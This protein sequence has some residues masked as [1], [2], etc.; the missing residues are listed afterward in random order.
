MNPANTT[1]P[2]LLR[3]HVHPEVLMMISTA[4]HVDHGKTRLVMM[5]TGCQTDRLKEEQERGLTIELG[6]APC[7]LGDNLCVGIV[8]VPGHERFV[9]TMVAGVSGIDLTILIIAADDGVMPQTVEHLQIM[10][11]LGVRHGIVA[12]T[13]TDLVEPAQVERRTAEIAAFLRGSF[14]EGAPICPVSSETGEG[15]AEF[16]DLLVKRIRALQRRS[17]SG[18]FR[19]PVERV[20]SQQ[21]FG[22]VVTG[23]PLAGLIRVGDAVALQPG[24]QVGRVRGVQCFMRD[25]E[26]GGAGQCLALNVPEWGKSP[27]VRGQVIVPP[28]Y[29]P[30]A[31]Q[32]HVRL[33]AVPRLDPPLRNAEE[34][35]FHTGTAEAQ[36][37]I[38]LLEDKTLAG[39][40]ET[41]ATVVTTR[42]VAAASGD[43][44]I[45]R[46]ASTMTTVAGGRIRLSSA[47][48]MRPRRQVLLKQLTDWETFF[49]D[50]DP[51]SAEGIG[52]RVEYAVR[53]RGAHG[54]TAVEAGRDALVSTEAA[55]AAL[56][57]LR[58]AGRLLELKGG[59]VLHMDGFRDCRA[60]LERRLTQAR[61]TEKRLNLPVNE[62]RQGLDWSAAVWTAVCRDLE[63]DGRVSVQGEVILLQSTMDGL[64]EADRNLAQRLL[65]VFE[66][67]GYHSPRPDELPERLG[68]P[69][70]ATGRMLDFLLRQKKLVKV[71]DHV[72]LAYTHYRA[73]QDLVLATIQRDGVLNSPAFRD[74]L[75][76]TRK[77]AMSILDFMDRQRITVRIQ[78]D[79]RL[80]TGYER[81]LL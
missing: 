54:A 61:D 59:A 71:E 12:L 40:A 72:V 46:R 5:L 31:T 33:R 60:E 67:S 77:Y 4:G 76:T 81:N 20:F 10:E 79:R 57:T 15:Y 37:K 34:V 75:Q 28:G 50:V 43:R 47:Q 21:G 8:D 11:L 7:F 70:A 62:C 68:V 52:R 56:A 74:Q 64:S 69:A 51:E 44:F 53:Q 38:F 39:G 1:P 3:P 35:Q 73:A 2:G 36:G 66:E 63:K 41:L 6:F 45:L 30:P 25:S 13:K 22:A 65:G 9:R 24:G 32:F 16:Y 55:T 17:G 58:E 78:N 26:E 49:A 27:P 14:M 48:P 42:P 29:L 80:M 19:M 23:I 18:V